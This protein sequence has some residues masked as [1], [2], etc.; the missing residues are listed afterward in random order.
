MES[1]HNAGDSPGGAL[2][3][4]WYFSALLEVISRVITR[5]DPR[6]SVYVPYTNFLFATVSLSDIRFSHSVNKLYFLVPRD[7][8]ATAMINT[9]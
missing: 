9:P 6:K 3:S 8:T 5:R 7:S 1:A 2:N 4:A